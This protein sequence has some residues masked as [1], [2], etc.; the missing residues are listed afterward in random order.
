MLCDEDAAVQNEVMYPCCGLWM[1]SAG[2]CFAADGDSMIKQ[3]YDL[4]SETC[5][6]ITS[7]LIVTKSQDN[8]TTL[9]CYVIWRSRMYCILCNLTR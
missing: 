1:C 2:L 6:V 4:Y 3:R 5:F 8:D 7:W 9:W